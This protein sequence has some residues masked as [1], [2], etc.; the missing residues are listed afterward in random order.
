MKTLYGLYRS[1]C[2]DPSELVFAFTDFER[3]R[4]YLTEQQIVTHIDLSAVIVDADM[5][6]EYHDGC[7]WGHVSLEVREIDFR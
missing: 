3:V 6:I 2:Y 4:E 7:I 1:E 5:E